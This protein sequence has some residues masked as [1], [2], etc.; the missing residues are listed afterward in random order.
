[1]TTRTA[2]SGLAAGALALLVA[3]PVTAAPTPDAKSSEQGRTAPSRRALDADLPTDRPI[4]AT[5]VEVDEKAGTVTLS[6]PHGD[7]AL[8]VS[9]ELVGRLSV[10]DIVVVRFTDEDDF[11][12][13]SPREAPPAEERQKI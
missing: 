4:V 5:V 6:T 12:S 13:A 3:A 8:T 10:G 2:L 11:P 1:M 7:V 9:Q